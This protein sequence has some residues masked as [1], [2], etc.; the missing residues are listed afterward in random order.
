MFKCYIYNSR[1][2]KRDLNV[3]APLVSVHNDTCKF[4][5]TCILLILNKISYTSY[6]LPQSS[7]FTHLVLNNR[8]SALY[9]DVVFCDLR[10]LIS[11]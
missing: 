9:C 8:L 5:K 7:G 1:E 10:K 6:S 3:H 4:A 11:I 2:L